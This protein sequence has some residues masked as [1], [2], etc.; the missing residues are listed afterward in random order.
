MRYSRLDLS[1]IDRLISLFGQSHINKNK[2]SANILRKLNHIYPDNKDEYSKIVDLYIDYLNSGVI[3]NFGRR[4]HII[5]SS[6]SLSE[7]LNFSNIKLEDDND[8]ADPLFVIGLPRSGTTNLH[9]MLIDNLNYSG[10]EYWQ[11]TSPSPIFENNSLDIFTRKA[12]SLLGFYIYRYLVPSIQ[13]MH[14]VK[15]NTYE[16]CWHF[17]KTMF[18]C[19]NYV[20][21][22]K[23][24]EFEDELFQMDTSFIHRQYKRLIQQNTQS[25]EVYA[26]K[27]PDHMMSLSTIDKVFP[28]SEIVW[29]HRD[30]YDSLLSYCSMVN[31]VWELFLGDT[32][33]KEVGQFV[34]ELFDRMIKRAISYQ[35]ESNKIVNISYNE[36]ISNRQ[37][38][39][40][41]LSKKLDRKIEISRQATQ[42]NFFKNKYNKN[43]YDY[44]ISKDEVYDRLSYYNDDF[45]DYLK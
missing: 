40:N 17:Q 1:I 3:T 22:L 42:S 20:I 8:I 43:K 29:I 31:S 9:N 16:E 33:K 2:A 37:K 39:I 25:N 38:V 26:L 6:I 27:C 32:D 15:M 13:S 11:L 34:L 10:F 36:L 28:K 23:F 30:P 19:Y 45:S 5:L 7:G 44:G 35:S 24:F 41:K 12:R 21:Q 18:L 14:K 4:A